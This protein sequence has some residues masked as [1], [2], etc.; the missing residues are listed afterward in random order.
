LAGPQITIREAEPP[1]LAAVRALLVETWHDTYDALIGTEKVTEITDSWHSIENLKR[2][3]AMPATAFFVAE[4]AGAIVG[5]AFAN[6]QRPPSLM[7]S[8]LYV[9]PL[10]QRRGIGTL[11]LAAAIERYPACNVVRLEVEAGNAKGLA[12]YRGQ[13]FHDVGERMEE[14]IGHIR[15]ERHVD[16]GT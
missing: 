4:Q 5:H 11:L 7:L 6:G 1:D 15:M 3:L 9:L 8:R 13:G 12:F 16:Q 2:Q 14:G 10:S